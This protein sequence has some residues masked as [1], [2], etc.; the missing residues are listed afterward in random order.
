MISSQ[1]F[2]TVPTGIPDMLYDLERFAF[3][4]FDPISIA[5][6]HIY[7]SALPFSPLNCKIRAHFGQ[8]LEQSV[9]ALNGTEQSWGP[10]LRIMEG[11]SD[12]VWAVTFSP[13]GKRIASGS[14]DCTV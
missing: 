14:N 1:T 8:E 7:Y 6:L 12:S 3:E 4:F 2:S 13:D 5:A 9:T 10:N 11:H